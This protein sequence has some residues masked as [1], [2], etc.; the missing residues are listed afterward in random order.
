[1]P[2]ETQ[3]HPKRVGVKP[4]NRHPAMLLNL[5]SMTAQRSAAA[6]FDIAANVHLE[7]G[8]RDGPHHTAAHGACAAEDDPLDVVLGV[9]RIGRVPDARVRQDRRHRIGGQFPG[10][11]QGPDSGGDALALRFEAGEGLR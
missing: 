5:T 4:Q 1:M 9:H 7:F 8:R 6:V 10:L 2:V 11:L 3:G